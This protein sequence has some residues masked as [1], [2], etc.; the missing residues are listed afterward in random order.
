M[1]ADGTARRPKRPRLDRLTSAWLVAALVTALLT[2]TT[3]GVLPQAWW[4]SIHV[5]TLGVLTSS[6]LQWSWYFARAL[7]HL[8]ADDKRSG[9]DATVRMLVFQAALVG[10]V[11]SMWTAQVAGTVAAATAVGAVIAWHGLALVRAARTRLGNR[12]AVVVRYYVA[13]A[14]FLVVGCALAGSITVA[15]FA[16]TAPDWLV[17]ARDGLTA[18]HAV[19]NLGGWIGLSITGTLVTLGPTMLRTRI[20]PGALEAAVRALPV[21]VAALSVAAVA[22]VVDRPVGVGAGVLAAGAA[23]LWGV[24]LPLARAARTASAGAFAPWTLAAGLT[25][26]A[27]A[28][29]AYAVRASTAHDVGALR[30]AALPW[31]VLLGAGGVLQVFVAALTYL[32]PVV[33]GGGPGPL[34]TGMATLETAWPARVAARNAALALVLVGTVTGSGPGLA[35]WAVVLVTYAADV[36]LLA[37][38]GVRQAR[39]RPPGGGVPLPVPLPS[40][41]RSDS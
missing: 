35:W 26:V 40:P 7:L 29:A 9:R 10:L 2:F 22:A 41:T 32:M 24:G 6:V 13:A 25:W 30:S 19:V 18:A 14:A 8:P 31:L 5:V 17:D 3:R 39:A 37:R 33:I 21:M 28:V 27:V 12:F 4:T 20:D 11:A 16:R 15:M 1:S 34:R 38:A 36:A 23:A